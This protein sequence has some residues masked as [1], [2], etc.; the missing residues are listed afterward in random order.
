M[1][2]GLSSATDPT[3]RNCSNPS[4]EAHHGHVV[5]GTGD[6]LLCEFASA[7]DAVEC[8][9]EIQRAMPARE[10]G[11]P[12]DRRIEYRIG[13]NVGDIVV[14]GGDITATG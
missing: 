1:R 7:V 5:K 14:E 10:E 4:V 9:V 11:I 13:I 6:G 8:A 12:T 3:S 2:R